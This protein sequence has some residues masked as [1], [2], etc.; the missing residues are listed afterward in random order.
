MNELPAYLKY[1][2]RW[3][4]ILRISLVQCFHG[5][6]HAYGWGKPQKYLTFS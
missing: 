2:T 3:F 5:Q 4:F 6:T 1:K